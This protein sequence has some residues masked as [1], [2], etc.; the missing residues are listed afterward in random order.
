MA[1][2]R[3]GGTDPYEEYWR[4]SHQEEEKRIDRRYRN[5]K[6]E[7]G[8]RRESTVKR[9]SHS[10][11]SQKKVERRREGKYLPYLAITQ[12]LE[13]NREMAERQLK[14]KRLSEG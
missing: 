12:L 4:V 13:K 3:E 7:R 6:N 5:T 1:R 9:E 11:A 8:E 10:V 14:K 2:I